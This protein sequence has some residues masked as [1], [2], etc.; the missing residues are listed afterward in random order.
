MSQERSL[1]LLVKFGEKKIPPWAQGPQPPYPPAGRRRR[2]HRGAGP[3]PGK[4]KNFNFYF[5]KKKKEKP[6]LKLFSCKCF[7]S[8]YPYFVMIATVFF[9]IQIH[10]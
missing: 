1:S 10:T 7:E 9:L 3:P 8:K 4:K 5:A 6:N 2:R